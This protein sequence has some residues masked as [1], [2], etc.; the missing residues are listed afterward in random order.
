MHLLLVLRSVIQIT[1]LITHVN[2]CD[3]NNFIDY[4]YDRVCAPNKVKN[5]NA[6]FYTALTP[7]WV[8]T[9]SHVLR[10]PTVGKHLN[11]FISCSPPYV[12]THNRN[13]GLY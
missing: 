11:P 7:Y 3:G 5:M 9:F 2:K 10:I 1:L 8:I 12:V 6:N 4:P 13:S